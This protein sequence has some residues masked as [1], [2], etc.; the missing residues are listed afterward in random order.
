MRDEQARVTRRTVV[1]AAGELFV[2]RGYAATT[3]DAVADRARVSRRTVFTSVGGKA[4]LLKLAWDWSLAGD[5]EPVPIAERPSVRRIQEQ[6]DPIVVLRMQARHIREV[7]GRVAALDRVIAV[8]A[9]VDPEATA[10]RDSI[11]QQRLTGATLFVRWLRDRGWLRRGLSVRHGAEL[12]WILMDPA[13]Y[14]WLV[15]ERRWSTRQFERYLTDSL[16]ALLL[17]DSAV[18]SP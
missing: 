4:A 18:R 9:D 7:S 12:C 17:G 16:A 11:E 5:D 3:I 2:E 10:L 8:A 15:T 1:S 6:T 13:G 14:R